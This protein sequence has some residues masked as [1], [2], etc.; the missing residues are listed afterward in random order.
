MAVSKPRPRRK[1]EEF[2]TGAKYADSAPTKVL[3]SITRIPG[4]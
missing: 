4:R 3:K 2:S 1:K